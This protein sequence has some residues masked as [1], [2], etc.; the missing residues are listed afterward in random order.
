MQAWTKKFFAKNVLGLSSLFSFV[1]DNG[2]FLLGRR[3]TLDIIAPVRSAPWQ[4]RAT[5][6]TVFINL[7]IAYPLSEVCGDVQ[8]SLHGL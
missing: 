2:V 3:S 5:L 4:C 6:G 7:F 8:S 1:P